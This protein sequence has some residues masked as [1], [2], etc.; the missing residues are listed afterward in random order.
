M[1]PTGDDDASTLTERQEGL[2][3]SPDPDEDLTTGDPTA[4]GTPEPADATSP[5][6]AVD[7]TR[8]G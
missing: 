3:P 1:P 8:P 4:N 5:T 7:G 2:D 6:D